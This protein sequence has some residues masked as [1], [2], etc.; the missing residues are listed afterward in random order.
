MKG[1]TSD[2]SSRHAPPLYPAAIPAMK[3]VLSDR[4]IRHA[5][6]RTRK[7]IFFILFFIG[8]IF[9]SYNYFKIVNLRLR[10]QKSTPSSTQNNEQYS[11]HCGDEFKIANIAVVITSSWGPSHP[12][13]YLIEA[14]INSTYRRLIGLPSVTPIFITVDHFR[15][16]ENKNNLRELEE[17]ISDVEEYTNNLLHLYQSNRH[18]HI[19]PNMKHLH[20]GGSIMKAMELIS[21]HYPNVKYMY[22]LQHDFSFTRYIDHT[23][24]IDAME[25]HPGKVNYIR[26]PKRPI[27]SMKKGCSDE[28]PIRY[29]LT[30][31]FYLTYLSK[32]VED[33]D[34]YIRGGNNDNYINTTTLQRTLTPTYSYSDNNHLVNFTWMK[35]K[36]ASMISLARPPEDPIS[37][38]ALNGCLRN[39]SK[40]RPQFWMTGLY[41]YY[42][43]CIEHLDGDTFMLPTSS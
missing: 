25:N 5:R 7:F 19:L 43:M 32:K 20:I 38:R 27:A 3:E 41:L 39:D 35:E 21:R 30:M 16:P 40:I 22:S 37:S 13:T 34:F 6:R 36:I 31:P 10:H 2:S 8:C 23:A 12:S 24:L 17:K 18:V 42:E 33:T 1:F 28:L 14:V 9:F 4:S 15:Y 29:H 26:F 11:T